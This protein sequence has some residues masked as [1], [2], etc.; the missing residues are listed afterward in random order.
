[1]GTGK[2]ASFDDFS[3]IDL[4]VGKVI[5]CEPVEGSEKLYKLTVRLGEE[6]RTIA[7]GIAQHYAPDELLGK[8]IIVIANLEPKTVMG[9]ESR[10]MLLAAEDAAGKLSLVTL[11]DENFPDGTQVH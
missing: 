6:T 9:I 5:E 4:R 1:M 7:S 11:D 3:K 8:R 10:G 2:N